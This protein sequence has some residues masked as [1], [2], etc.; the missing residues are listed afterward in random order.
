MINLLIGIVGPLGSGKTLT[1]IRLAL[2]QK[3]KGR[4]VWANIKVSFADLVAPAEILLLKMARERTITPRF[5]IIDE[6]GQIMNAA[7]WA[8]SESRL[9]SPIF[10]RS[11]KLGYDIAW[12]SQTLN[13]VNINIRRIT[14]VLIVCEFLEKSRKIRNY[15]FQGE[16]L[17]KKNTYDSQVYYKYYDTREIV[18]MNRG[19][20][21]SE[22][23]KMTRG[24]TPEEIADELGV[25]ITLA[26]RI[27]RVK[28]EAVNEEL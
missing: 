2:F 22:L 18:E 5:V 28:K 20:L 4:E 26:K 8:T 16:Q 3:M 7:D 10:A 17:V 9:L 6:I 13:M 15:V 23:A 27:S 1:A 11:R 12:T 19:E 14:D 24:M 25:K 21:I